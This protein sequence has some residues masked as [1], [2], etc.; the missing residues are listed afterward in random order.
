MVEFTSKEILAIRD[1]SYRKL[2]DE[3]SPVLGHIADIA[4]ARAMIEATLEKLGKEAPV[5]TGE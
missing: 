3:G 4:F 5:R 1:L 2:R